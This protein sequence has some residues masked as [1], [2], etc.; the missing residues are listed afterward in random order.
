MRQA[1]LVKRWLGTKVAR[2]DQ[3]PAKRPTIKDVA[4]RAGVS[5]K[6]VSRVLNG[7]AS[8]NADI[9]AA[10]EQA[11]AQLDYRPNRAARTMRGNRSFAVAVLAGG[12]DEPA[13]GAAVQFPPFMGDVVAGAAQ[14]C[15]PAGYHLVLELLAYGDQARAAAITT[16]LLD[17]VA[18]DGV[19]LVP[20]LSDLGWLLDLLETRG[21]PHVRLMPGAEPG[22]GL[23][24]ALDDHA[25]AKAMTQ[26]LLDLGHRRIGFISGPADHL[27]A[28]DR[29]AGFAAAI[30]A[31][32]G[33]SAVHDAGDFYMASGEAA[34]ARLLAL[35]DRPTAIFAANDSMAAGALRAA[36]ARGLSVP[37]DVSV[38]GFDDSTVA[39]LTV[40]A[41]TT[42][43]QPVRDMARHAVAM[44]ITA[45]QGH[46]APPARQFTCELVQRASTA[47]I[48]KKGRE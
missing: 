10:V 12:R 19:V 42:V 34:A 39:Q 2:Q 27:A 1:T 45:A 15:R 18:P 37:G 41:L 28:A 43:R 22:R 23:S 11:M 4:A 47:P 35:P 46:K 13:D 38:A 3:S 6:T 33:A 32:P 30:K 14:G 26:A 9:R 29:R 7:E 17:D 44:L 36:M 21:V 24:L 40:P 20:P 25:A 16:A 8:V 31:C 48:T 5:F